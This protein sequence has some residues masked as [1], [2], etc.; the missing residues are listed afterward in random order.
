MRIPLEERFLRHVNKTDTCWLWTGTTSGSTAR[1]GYFRVGPRQAD[2]KVPAHRVAYE[3]WVGPIPT[4]DEI[5][6]VADRGCTSKLC[7]NPAHL[8]PVT[9]AE[10]RKRGRLKVCRAGLHDLTD[11]ANM[12]WDS[13]GQRRGCYTCKKQAL[14]KRYRRTK[15]N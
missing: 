7:V 14:R 3:L 5:D 15:E 12:L 13:K 2:P 1:Y 11:P 10:N 6:H 9:H 8:E 4:G